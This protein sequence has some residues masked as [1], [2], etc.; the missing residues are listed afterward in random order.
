[1]WTLSIIVVA[2]T[3]FIACIISCVVNSRRDDPHAGDP[4]NIVLQKTLF[5][6]APAPAYTLILWS[7]QYGPY[8]EVLAFPILM[9]LAAVVPTFII[10]YVAH[11][12]TPPA[13]SP[14]QGFQVLADSSR[15]P[16]SPS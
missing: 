8:L 6:S 13:P 15:N 9:Y 5:W 10:A 1:M 16:P 7:I 11:R 4:L 12:I 3:G 14:P 2:F